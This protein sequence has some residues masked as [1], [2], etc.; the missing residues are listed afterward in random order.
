MAKK[1][2]KQELKGSS[3]EMTLAEARAYRA[4]LHKPVIAEL[5]LEQKREE[6]RKF[7]AQNR[8]KYNKS[9]DLEQVLWLHLKAVK[10]E[11]PD[12]FEAGLAHFGLKK[13]GQ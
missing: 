1:E 11:S 5:S 8:A 3:E 13:I 2:S 10:M 12:K 6:F 9:R 4:A 7:W